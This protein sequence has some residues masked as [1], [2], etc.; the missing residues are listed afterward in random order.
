METLELLRALEPLSVADIERR[1]GGFASGWKIAGIC[2]DNRFTLE[3]KG[4]YHVFRYHVG[5]N[6]AYPSARFHSKDAARAY[7][8][9]EWAK[10]RR[11]VYEERCDEYEED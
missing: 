5:D 6:K 9:D 1:V 3:H 8:F 4:E 2:L 11:M 7:V 10:P